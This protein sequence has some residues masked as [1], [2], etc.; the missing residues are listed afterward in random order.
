MTF[1]I[2]VGCST[3]QNVSKGT[4]SYDS[5]AIP[6]G[7]GLWYNLPKTVVRVEMVAEKVVVRPGPFFR[8]SQRLLNI[9]EVETESREEWRIVGAN[10]STVGIPD[11]KR[12]Y[13]ILT[14][15]SPS[16]A[17][18]N[19]TH[20]GVLAGIN[21]TSFVEPVI[22][23]K[24]KK[25][26][27]I[28][29]SSVHFND[30]GY[31]GEQLIKS[32]TSAMAEEVAKEIYRLRQLRNQIVKGEVELLPPDE[33]SYQ[34][35][36][37]EIDRQE[38]AFVELFTGKV[39]I[40]TI[41]QNF[42][43]IPEP[44]QSLNTVLLRF[45]KQNGFLDPMDVSGTPVYIEVDVD[46]RQSRN[47]VAVETSKSPN[48]SGLVYCKPVSAQIKIIDRTLLLTNENVQLAQFGQVLRMPA[49]LL[50]GQGIGVEL[51]ITTG[52]LKNIFYK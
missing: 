3:S 28:D 16:L 36:L 37:K 52:A 6:S 1:A 8:F 13:R 26:N 45:S 39:V 10:I 27:I 50:N 32:S 2:M 49:D 43:F 30:V 7:H 35:A 14:N 40:Q 24:V 33:G 34:L 18:I 17:A 41:K 46:T 42:D 5:G 19:L 48:T 20:D 47:F 21:M 9:T 31:S 4:V 11:S 38:K 15:G 29:M 23:H 12:Q 22:G 25:E 44:D 51:D